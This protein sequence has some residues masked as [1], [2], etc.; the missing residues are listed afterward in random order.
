[1]FFILPLADIRKK[2]HPILFA[3]GCFACVLKFVALSHNIAMLSIASLIMGV[4]SVT[5]QLILPLSA[6]LPSE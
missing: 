6:Q 4:T 3:M 2:K 5:P 1:M